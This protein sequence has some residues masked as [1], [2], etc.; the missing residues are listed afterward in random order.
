MNNPRISTHLGTVRREC[1]SAVTRA[2][3]GRSRRVLS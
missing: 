1:A 2:G 3:R